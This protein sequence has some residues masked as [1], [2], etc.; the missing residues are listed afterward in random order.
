MEASAHTSRV[1]P[2]PC[3]RI[4]A[5]LLSGRGDRRGRPSSNHH[6]YSQV[7]VLD[8]SF[9]KRWSSVFFWRD[10]RY[11]APA[12]PMLHK[13]GA[14]DLAS[15][16]LVRSTLAPKPPTA[17]SFTHKTQPANIGGFLAVGGG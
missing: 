9:R 3:W 14:V 16:G 10:S 13:L 12:R 1:V 5:S 15:F 11:Y 2:Y 7:K 17:D 8:H 4:A 6:Y